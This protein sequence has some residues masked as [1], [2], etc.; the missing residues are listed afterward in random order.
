MGFG[1][2]LGQSDTNLLFSLCS[3]PPSDCFIIKDGSGTVSVA[4]GGF[5]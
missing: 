5:T 1:G 2:V 4:E 3:D